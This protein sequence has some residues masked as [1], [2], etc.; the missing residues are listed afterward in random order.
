MLRSLT[1]MDKLDTTEVTIILTTPEAMMFREFQQFH[2]TFVLLVE[3]GVFDIQFGKAT[4]N[5]QQGQLQNITKEE[6]VWR[7]A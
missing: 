1:G 4:L 2:A 3:K 7:K 6:I 5:F